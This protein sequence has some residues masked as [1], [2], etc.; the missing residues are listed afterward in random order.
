M[1]QRVLP[2]L[3]SLALGFA[4]TKK[5]NS[6]ILLDTSKMISRLMFRISRLINVS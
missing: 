6:Q 1:T 2:N 5:V 4:V 3:G